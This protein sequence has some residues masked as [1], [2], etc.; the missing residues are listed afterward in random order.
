MTKKLLKLKNLMPKFEL[1]LPKN[2]GFTISESIGLELKA[3]FAFDAVAVVSVAA[4]DVI[5]PFAAAA[6]VIKVAVVATTAAC[7]CS[8]CCFLLQSNSTET[9]SDEAKNEDESGKNFE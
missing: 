4:I 9:S 7:C 2:L 5:V 1:I 3:Q 6:A 8:C